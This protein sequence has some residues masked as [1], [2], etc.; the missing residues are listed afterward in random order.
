MI[1]REL[2]NKYNLSNNLIR[3]WYHKKQK[4]KYGAIKSV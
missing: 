3:E 2:L 1:D 4:A